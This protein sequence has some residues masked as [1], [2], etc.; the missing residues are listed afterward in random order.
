MAKIRVVQ[1]KTGQYGLRKSEVGM[2][3]FDREHSYFNTV[4]ACWERDYGRGPD[5]WCKVSDQ[6]YLLERYERYVEH[7][8]RIADMENDIGKPLPGQSLIERSWEAA[9]EV[10]NGFRILLFMKD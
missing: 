10:V 7:M 4:R 1:F 2:F 3:I 9:C 6:K 8:Q 5:E